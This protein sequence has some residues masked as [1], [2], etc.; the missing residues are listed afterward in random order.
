MTATPTAIG[1]PDDT[2]CLRPGDL[3]VRPLPSQV[4]RT[5]ALTPR[6]NVATVTITLVGH[7]I[8]ALVLG[9]ALLKAPRGR[10]RS[11]W[12][13]PPLFESAPGQAGCPRLRE[14]H[15]STVSVR[16]PGTSC[17]G[18]NCLDRRSHVV[19]PGNLETVGARAGSAQR[20]AGDPR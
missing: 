9:L 3:P 12:P 14:V 4:A 13:W 6:L 10:D 2:V 15:Q 5:D 20:S 18:Q 8:F 16:R 11:E 1:W 7:L 19:A 17:L